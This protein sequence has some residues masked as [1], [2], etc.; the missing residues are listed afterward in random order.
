MTDNRIELPKITVY[1][2]EGN[3]IA[4]AMEIYPSYFR[5]IFTNITNDNASWFRTREHFNRAEVILTA[6][7]VRFF[8]TWNVGF[9]LNWKVLF[10]NNDNFTKLPRVWHYQIWYVLQNLQSD[11][12]S[13][14]VLRTEE[15]GGRCRNM[16]SFPKILLSIV[17]ICELLTCLP[18]W[19]KWVLTCFIDSW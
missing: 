9:N 5:C 19:A 7:Q 10:K 17:A 11:T 6:L 3:V 14:S 4:V 1:M 13:S 15:F 2:R 18:Y 12:L 16:I 8:S